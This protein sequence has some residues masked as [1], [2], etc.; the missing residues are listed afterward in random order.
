MSN[1][2]KSVL[3][4][5]IFFR[6]INTKNPTSFSR[7][8][9]FSVVFFYLYIMSFQSAFAQ[10]YEVS[11]VDKMQ[12][13]TLVVEAKVIQKQS[14]WNDAN[15]RIFTA[16]EIEIYK[17]FKGQLPSGNYQIITQGGIVGSDK[18]EVRPSLQL[19]VGD[20]GVYFLE[21]LSANLSAV[22]GLKLSAIAEQQGFYK[23]DEISGKA[24][25][26]FDYNQTVNQL[27]TA[28][29]AQTNQTVTQNIS[30]TFSTISFPE[31]LPPQITGISPTTLNAGVGDILT[32]TGS[33]FDIQLPT[34]K[35]MLYDA[36]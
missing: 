6:E 1:L 9:L 2:Y 20:I 21:S 19:S 17:V 33:G 31:G 22:N 16:N 13:A 18:H 32:I 23:Y 14:Y 7:R 35:V 30:Y 26:P 34:S 10:M 11:F 27:H 28:I 25:S 4:K 5:Y 24:V 8:L 3:H 15:N 29:Q 12:E 36:A